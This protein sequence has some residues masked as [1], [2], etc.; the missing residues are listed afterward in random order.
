MDVS[1]QP[2][3]N[4]FIV[5]QTGQAGAN[6]AAELTFDDRID[7]LGFPALT[8]RLHPGEQFRLN[9]IHLPFSTRRRYRG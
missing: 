8:K 2:F 9:A 5:L 6:A 7:S 3:D 1:D 4:G